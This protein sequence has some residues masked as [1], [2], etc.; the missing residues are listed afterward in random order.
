MEPFFLP[1]M[2]RVER[3]SHNEPI[4]FRRMPHVTMSSCNLEHGQSLGDHDRLYH[5]VSRAPTDGGVTL[6]HL[7]QTLFKR[8]QTNIQDGTSRVL[9]LSSRQND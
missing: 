6:G 8:F 1:R 9:T 3:S 2:L 5:K 4:P 7:N